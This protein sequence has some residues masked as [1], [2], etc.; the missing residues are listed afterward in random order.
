[1]LRL[2]ESFEVARKSNSFQPVFCQRT[3]VSVRSSSSGHIACFSFFRTQMT[4]T[5][6]AACPWFGFGDNAKDNGNKLFKDVW[7]HI[8]VLRC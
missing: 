5:Q 7:R 8:L 4:N 6:Q 2:E 3:C 1:M